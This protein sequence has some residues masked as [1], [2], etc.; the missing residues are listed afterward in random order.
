MVDVKSEMNPYKNISL[1]SDRLKL[2]PCPIGKKGI[3]CKI[4]LMGPCRVV[5]DKQLGVCGASQDL[6]VSRNILRFVAG[7]AAAHSG[8]TY[9]MIEYFDD[10]YTKDYIA[11]KAPKYLYGLWDE[12]GLLPKVKMEHFKDIS[13]ALHAS[14]MGVNSDWQDI[15]K[16]CIKLG[17]VDGYFGLY[18]GTEIED[19][20]FG[21]PEIKKG[22]LNLGV[23][24]PDKVN[25][26][27]HGHEYM[28]AEA[29]VKEAAKYNNVN[30]VG[31]CCTGASLLSRLG[32]PLAGNLILQED[33]I[34]TGI[35]D[36]IAVDVQ[37]V[38]PSLSD[39]CDCFHTKLIT[40]NEIARIPKAL[41]MP[42]KSE[43][44][45][46]NT[47]KKIIEL[48][49]ANKANRRTGAEKLFAS[50]KQEQKEVTVGF[51]EDNIDVDKIA[52]R[53]AKKEIKGVIAVL[54][55]VNPRAE[56]NW[57]E[58][59]D[60]LRKDY[61]ILT[62]GCIAFEFGKNGL[63]DGKNVFHLGSCVNN[64][65]VAEIFKRIADKSG[66]QIT[67]LPFLV[68]CPMPITEKAM[69]IGFFFA[70]LGVDVHV[71]YPFL[72]SS[73]TNVAGFLAT[74]LQDKFRSK[75]FVDTA[76]ESL[77]KKIKDGLVV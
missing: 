59:F 3:C 77:Y 39:L 1:L 30:I 24:D 71:G 5:S 47:A 26:C 66:K 50:K 34:A 54:G 55:C 19:K 73:D 14:T 27:V 40:T 29:L 28:F 60:K 62:T 22:K 6:I 11:R 2:E 70:A 23:L 42:V 31:V 51:T 44:D 69:A 64:A 61:L 10:D 13:E 21:K 9:H 32:V 12:L 33:V 48:A 58:M 65:R 20:Y 49:I 4:C 74:T 38:M 75:I 16:W 57:I 25:I 72:L 18:L 37:C 43:E 52:K 35:V 41:H 17:I 45:A 7:G 56:Q 15:L 63:L 67:D 76:P 68:S 8:H 46:K 53:I 36:A